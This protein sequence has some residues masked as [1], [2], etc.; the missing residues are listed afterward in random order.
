MASGCSVELIVLRYSVR[1][2][3]IG[4]CLMLEHPLWSFL[5]LILL[6]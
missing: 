5:P 6:R 1:F 4:E 2:V 3:R